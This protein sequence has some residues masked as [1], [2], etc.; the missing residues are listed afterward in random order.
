MQRLPQSWIHIHPLPS[1]DNPPPQ[2]YNE[3]H[4]TPELPTPS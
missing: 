1:T 3:S 4:K 2:Y